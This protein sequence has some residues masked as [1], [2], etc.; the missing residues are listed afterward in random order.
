MLNLFAVDA[1]ILR[2]SSCI[3]CTTFGKKKITRSVQAMEILRHKWNS[4]QMILTEIVF[5]AVQ[6]V[7]IDWNGEVMLGLGQKNTTFEPFTLP[8]QL[9]KVIRGH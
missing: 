8:R 7:S 3:L 9:S 1:E 6:L 4:L 2:S 5:A